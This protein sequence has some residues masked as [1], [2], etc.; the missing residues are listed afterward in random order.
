MRV[1]L[2]LLL[3]I[4]ITYAKS[5]DTCY[6]VQLTSFK[7]KKN[8]TYDFAKQNYPESCRLISFSNI[9]SIRCGCY[10]KYSDARKALKK[11]SK[12]YPNPLIVNT[13]KY[14]FKKKT[15]KIAKKPVKITPKIETVQKKTLHVN[16]EVK[17]K[18]E[19]GFLDNV[20]YQGNIDMTLQS[21]MKAPAGKEKQ[22]ALLSANLETKYIQENFTAFAKV[23]LQQDYYDLQGTA[24]HTKRSSVRLDELYGSYDFDDDTI[25]FGK[26]ILFWGALEVRN[27][28]NVFNPDELRSDPF[29]TDKLGVINFAYTHYTESGELSAI[30]K[31][32]E[33]DRNMPAYPYVYYYFSAT[34]RVSPNVNLPLL[35]DD[36]LKTKASRY[37]PSIYLK[38]SD[39]TDTEY[40][41]D[42][43]FIFENGYDSQRYYTKTLQINNIV[44]TQENAYLVNKFMTYDTLV[45]G[46]TLYKLE[47]AYTDIIDDA[48]ISD[49]IHI[50]LGAEHTLTQVYKEADLGLLVEYYRYITLQNGK[51]DDLDL[52]ELF[53]NDLFLGLRYSFNQGNDASIVGGGIFDLDYNEQVYYMEYQTRLMDTFKLNFDYRYISPSKNYNTAFKL[54]GAHERISLKLGYYF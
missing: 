36:T 28:V 51:K 34:V 3:S 50:G 27:L 39:S 9:N 11:L 10:E 46:A 47:A 35:Y 2:L 40:A 33:Q 45:I 12:H 22:N 15:V 23:R 31:L 25:L 32:Y 37:R 26:N 30:I 17:E 19:S 8:S 41:L 13:Y 21:Y 6:S 18:E 53:Q 54:M 7:F 14:R 43:A 52:F 16:K 38:Y 24:K 42:Y 20:T 49:Y 44:T 4:S 5:N 1:L 29:Y 48:L